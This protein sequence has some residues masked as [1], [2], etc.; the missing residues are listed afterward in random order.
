MTP[1]STPAPEHPLLLPLPLKPEGVTAAWLTAALRQR[2]PEVVVTSAD[3]VDVMLG[4]STKIRVRLSCAGPGAES[5]PS[6]IIVKGGFEDHSQDMGPMY[7]NEARFYADIQPRLS[8]PSPTCY[9]A[10]S[11]PSSH[12][13]IV[14]MEDLRRPGVEFCDP[15]R[16]QTYDQV[17]RRIDAM[18]RYHA[19]TWE[20]PEFEPGGRWADI[21]SRFETWGLEFMN[22]FLVPEVWDFYMASPRGAAA[23][24]TWHDREW[25]KHALHEIGRIQFEQPRCLIHGDTHLGN[26]YIVEDGSPGFFDAQVARTAWHHEV[27]YHIA[28]ALDQADRPRWEVP[29]LERYLTALASHGVAAPSFDAA[30]LDYRRSLVWGLFI[31]LTNPTK[32]QTEA[33]NTAYASRFSQAAL[34]HDLKRLI[35]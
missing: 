26:L 12:Q 13:S 30:W 23:S 15:L 33:V 19:E 10:G 8:M 21:G 6:S 9:F 1:A 32:Y 35:G 5:L 31:F 11:D 27:S 29:L 4:T 34:D 18:A 20:S 22:R 24:V 25:M 28:C 14:I 2:R 7:A 16:P 3:I 17:A